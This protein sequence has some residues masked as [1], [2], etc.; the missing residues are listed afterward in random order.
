MEKY[1][2][3]PRS[4]EQCKGLLT[5]IGKMICVKAELI[6]TELLSIEDKQDMLNGLLPDEA[7]LLH[8][9]C[10]IEAGMPNHNS[11]ENPSNL[12][13]KTKPHKMLWKDGKWV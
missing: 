11:P 4:V 3:I 2:P 10:W 1:Q 12:N 8:V 13:A 5:T 7:L 9:K 6:S